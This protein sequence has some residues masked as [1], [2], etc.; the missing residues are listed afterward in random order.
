MDCL[1]CKP[2]LEFCCVSIYSS[3]KG[4]FVLYG[5]PALYS[6]YDVILC[7]LLHNYDYIIAGKLYNS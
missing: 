7:I 5:L 3:F 6:N 4:L 1:C 2:L